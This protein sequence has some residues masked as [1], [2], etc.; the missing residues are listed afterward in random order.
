MQPQVQVAAGQPWWWKIT[1]FCCLAG[2][3]LLTTCVTLNCF[4]LGKYSYSKVPMAVGE[5]E[6]TAN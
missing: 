4:R 6:R 2:R 3:N 5:L 1:F